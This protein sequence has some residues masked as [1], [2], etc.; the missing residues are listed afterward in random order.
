V[1]AFGA[2][3][4][5]SL[6]VGECSAVRPD[7]A[8]TE[9]VPHS[10]QQCGVSAPLHAPNLDEPLPFDGFQLSQNLT[11]C[12]EDSGHREGEAIDAT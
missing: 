7:S 12:G 9:A 10:D 2:T 11:D 3:Y 8:S 6:V 4:P 1:V 5:D